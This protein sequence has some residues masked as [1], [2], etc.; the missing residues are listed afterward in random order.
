MEAKILLADGR[1]D[2]ARPLAHALEREGY[3]VAWVG[4][5]REVLDALEAVDGERADLVILDLALPDMDGLEVCRS[6]REAGYDGAILIVTDRTAELDRVVGL[7]SGADDYVGTPFGVA[8][9]LARVRALL[10]RSRGRRR[11]DGAL[12]LDAEG[13][14]VYAG[15]AEVRLTG[16]EFDVLAVLEEHRDKVVPRERLMAEVWDENLFGSTK[17]LDVTIGRLRQKLERAGLPDRV[18]A[19]RGVGFRLE[20]T[21]HPE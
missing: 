17:A 11:L 7:D 21:R 5:G 19:V 12:R 4:S 13:R 1:H 2:V 3:D 16:K 15:D 20:Q 14:R 10:R 6:L 18:V 8:E 9:L